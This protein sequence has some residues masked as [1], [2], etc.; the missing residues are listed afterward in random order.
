MNEPTGQSNGGM[1]GI[2][3]LE[4]P[5]MVWGNPVGSRV[6]DVELWLIV[7]DRV[8]RQTVGWVQCDSDA[9]IESDQWISETMR[10]TF[11]RPSP[12]GPR[13]IA[14]RRSARAIWQ[15][16]TTRQAGTPSSGRTLAADWARS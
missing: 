4:Y 12:T 14:P 10:Q 6:D 15:E 1:V 8:I 16:A 9:R 11:R 2:I 3:S 7:R 13:A 5:G